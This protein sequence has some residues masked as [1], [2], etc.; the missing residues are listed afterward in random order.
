M[1]IRDSFLADIQQGTSTPATTTSTAPT[2]QRIQAP[3]GANPTTTN[4]KVDNTTIA[5]SLTTHQTPKGTSSSTN[6]PK[7]THP[8]QQQR[9]ATADEDF[10]D[11]DVAEHRM[12]NQLSEL[13]SEFGA[14]QQRPDTNGGVPSSSSSTASPSRI[15]VSSSTSMA[16]GNDFLRERRNSRDLRASK[17][18]NTGAISGAIK[19]GSHGCLLY[20]SP[21]PRDS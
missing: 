5:S 1:C 8:Q 15:G 4:I 20:T 12:Q 21:S 10:Y 16:V 13:L 18:G 19:K 6:P 17:E 3:H 14:N 7:P 2:V 11:H 9:S